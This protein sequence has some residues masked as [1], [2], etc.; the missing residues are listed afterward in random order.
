V[1]L[2]DRV[3][4]GK[5]LQPGCKRVAICLSGQPRTWKKCLPFWQDMFSASEEVHFDVFYHLWDFNTSPNFVFPPKN[6]ELDKTELDEIKQLL[7]PKRF[8]VEGQ[9][10]NPQAMLETAA[11]RKALTWQPKND[12]IAALW[13]CSQ[14]YSM[15]RAAHLKRSYEIDNGFEY[16]ACVRVRA[17]TSIPDLS[18]RYLRELTM[19]LPNTV[20]AV[21]CGWDERLMRPRIGDILY[22]SDSPTFDRMSDYFRFMHCID[23]S[24]L[25]VEPGEMGAQPEVALFFYT[26]MLNIRVFAL[27]IDTKV[28]RDERYV[29][30]LKARGLELGGHEVV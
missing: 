16:D 28:C 19:P 29:E 2:A 10:V 3:R 12:R 4:I 17:D 6:F 30:M 13:T 23:D 11:D 18:Q 26:K 7:K 20:H 8:L 14:F 5:G 25:G 15:M 9:S 21:H 1:K 24:F 22:Y 27:P